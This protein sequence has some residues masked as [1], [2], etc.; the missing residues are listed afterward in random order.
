MNRRETTKSK[1][2]LRVPLA[3]FITYH[4]YGTWLH[5]DKRGS[6]DR[7]FFNEVNGPR[8]PHRPNLENTERESMA[9]PTMILTGQMRAVVMEAIREVCRHRGYR[10]LALNIRSNHVHIVVSSSARPEQVMNTFK[11]IQT[12]KLREQDLIGANAKVWVRHGSTRYLWTDMQVG[13][14]INCVVFGQGDDLPD[15]NWTYGF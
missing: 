9:H 13:G 1:S 2:S 5:G 15:E 14:A 6:M 12:R 8:M 7:K 4:T 11:A 3:Y 10:L